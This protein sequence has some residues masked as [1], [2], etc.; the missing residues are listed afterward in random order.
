M[1]FPDH[2]DLLLRP[3]QGFWGTGENGI[4]FRGTG[5]QRPNF[6]GNRG[7]KT[8]LGNR[9]HNKTNFQFLG[10]REQANLFQGNKGTGTPLGGPHYL[11]V[12]VCG[13]GVIKT[14]SNAQWGVSDG[15]G[16]YPYG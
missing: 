9:E 3:S 7:T 10:N 4:Y 11:C 1:V 13:G 14:L 6:E 2:T 12:C 5:E 15:T 16:V 8:I